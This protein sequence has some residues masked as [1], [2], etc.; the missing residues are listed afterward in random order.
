MES[1]I[2]EL[3]IVT[4]E[5][6]QTLKTLI[7]H[8]NGENMFVKEKMESFISVTTDMKEV[9][10]IQTAVCIIYTLQRTR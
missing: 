6:Q 10:C 3:S 1:K 8:S 5:L 4:S 9:G 7:E 2:R